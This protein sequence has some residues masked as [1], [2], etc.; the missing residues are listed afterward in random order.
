MVTC[1]TSSPPSGLDTGGEFEVGVAEI[2]QLWDQMVDVLVLALACDATR[3]ATL[4]VTKM[5]IQ[6]G[7]EEFGMGDSENPN[8]A[9]RSNWHLQAHNWDDDARVVGSVRA[10]VGSPST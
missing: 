4:D 7:G 5:V 8:S 6:D 2:T 1:D 9:G 3:I 10:T